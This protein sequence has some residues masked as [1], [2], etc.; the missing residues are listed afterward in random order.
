[1]FNESFIISNFF[2]IIYNDIIYTIT[3]ITRHNIFPNKPGIKIIDKI[4]NVNAKLVH[5]EN[6]IMLP[7][8]ISIVFVDVWEIS[9]LYRKGASIK[10]YYFNM[11]LNNIR[12]YIKNNNKNYN[13]YY[14]YLFIILIYFILNN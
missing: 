4:K 2:S 5:W 10:C 8:L 7:L 12:K 6:L 3:I 1:M 13:K 9:L 11:R 14:L